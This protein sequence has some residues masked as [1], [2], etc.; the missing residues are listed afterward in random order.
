MAI[1]LLYGIVNA[2]TMESRTRHCIRSSRSSSTYKRLIGGGVDKRSL[3]MQRD[4]GMAEEAGQTQ[5]NRPN[6]SHNC[7][8][9]R[10][11]VR[12]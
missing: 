11:A 3:S 4:T 6:G 9:F 2:A 5:W 8:L 10:A 7:T 1:L 12:R